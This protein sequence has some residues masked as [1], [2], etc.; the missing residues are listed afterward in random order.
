MQTADFNTGFFTGINYWAS[1]NAI[2]MWRDFD[3]HVVENDFK[4][5]KNAGITHLRV[6]PL[7]PVFQPLT[8]LYGP[9]T[10]VYEYAFGEDPLPDTE[11]G[12]AG[13]SESACQ[14]F[15]VFCR[16]AQKHGL[17]LIVALI[18]GHMSFRTYCP[19]A[20]EGRELLSDPEVLKWQ[21][22]FVKYFVKRFSAQP[23][24][25]GW[26]LGNEPVHLPGCQNNPN[27]FYVWCTLI[28]DAARSCDPNHPIISGLD[29]S[30]IERSAS[31][32]KNISEMC[33]IHTTH[34]YHIFQ[35]SDDPLCSLKP[36]LD[37]P[38]RCQVSEDIAKIPTFIQEFG[39]IGYMNCSKKTE[40]E[41]YRGALW[42]SL[43]HGCHGVMW[44][45]AFDQGHLTY[46]PYRWNTIG[47]DYGFF[48]KDLQEKPLV[49]VNRE[50]QSVLKALPGGV[51]PPHKTQ[52]TVIIPR[53]DG[54]MNWNTLRATYILAAQANIDVNFCY[55]VDPIPKS[56]L[57]IFPS[58][59]GNKSIPKNRLDELL[60]FVEQGA[61]LYYSAD[62]GLFRQLP[63]ITGVEINARC[64]TAQ[65]QSIL[66]NG[67]AYP[68]LPT[69]TLTPGNFTAQILARNEKGE[70]VFFCNRLGKGRVYFLTLPLEKHLAQTKGVF[71]EKNAPEYFNLYR[72]L[73][74]KQG[75]TRL[76]ETPNPFVC[77][78]EHPCP[79]GSCYLVAINY[80]NEPVCTPLTLNRPLQV[81][82]PC[83][84]SFSS[85][86][87]QL[88]ANDGIILKCTPQPSIF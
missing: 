2:N 41:F 20:F 53:D 30:D 46:A 43:A 23:A 54:S 26:D 83:G 51:L 77:L 25:L 31:N 84:G 44:W 72:L 34:P 40:A 4:L 67:K 87:L 14:K 38:F 78:T 80:S 8:A 3:E 36:I 37:L 15:E 29:N 49:A 65:P 47:S 33:D 42:A 24:I 52:A 50:F 73:A 56:D 39:A 66:L 18:T 27:I 45:C 69:Y 79:D 71:F 35:T 64:K 5:L 21:V 57:Y 58:V 60:H 74:Q 88:N 32:F 62:T 76:A 48:T 85:G 61:A 6:F 75:L 12:R 82:T 86:N 1:N 11:A 7:W 55:A 13:V 68:V 19:P 70:P 10:K 81:T 59:E 22:R 63:E 16:L 9:T 28:A 17:K